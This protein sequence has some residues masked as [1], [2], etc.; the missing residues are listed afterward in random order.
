MMCLHGAGECSF[1]VINFLCVLVYVRGFLGIEIGS[2]DTD[3]TSKDLL[4]QGF[5]PSF[6][7]F[8]VSH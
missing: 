5:M 3:W 8:L 6:G 1:A 7:I 2:D 4:V